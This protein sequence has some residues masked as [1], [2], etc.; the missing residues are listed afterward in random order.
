[1]GATLAAVAL[2]A[3]PAPS[4][5][6]IKIDPA[7]SEA[8]RRA[9]GAALAELKRNPLGKVIVEGLERHQRTVT[10]T[11]TTT[12][13]GGEATPSDATNASLG[14][15]GRTTGKGS[16]STVSWNPSDTEQCPDDP[17]V[18]ADPAAQLLHELSHSL[19][20]A[21]G[22]DDG[23][24]NDK[25]GIT[26]AEVRAVRDENVY[27]AKKGL[28]QRRYY[29]FGRFGSSNKLPDDVIF[30]AE[31]APPATPPIPPAEPSAGGSRGGPTDGGTPPGD[32]TTGGDAPGTDTTGSD[33]TGGDTTGGG[34]TGGDTT[35]GDT[36]GGGTTGGDTTG[37]DTTGGG[38]TGGGT[39]GGGTTGGGTTGGGTTGGGTTGGGTT[40]GGGP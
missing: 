27:R 15:D 29:G 11:F 4:L 12:P 22:R 38:T 3:S 9:L 34:T 17:A 18:R 8:D 10:I 35:G 30:K 21:Y 2:L 24:E 23:R 6:D 31:P 36:T 16:D 32:D 1:M 25:T 19:D 20:F 14:G 40:G 37:G 33:T 28:P 26:Q 5:A 13:L 39:T 7:A